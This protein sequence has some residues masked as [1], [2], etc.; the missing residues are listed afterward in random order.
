MEVITFL[1]TL[2]LRRI[3]LLP[4][5]L[6]AMVFAIVRWKRHPR[7]SLMTV[8]ALVIYLF[9]SLTFAIILHWLPSLLRALTQTYQGLITVQNVLLV[10]EDF[11]YAGVLILLVAAA[12][13]QRPRQ[14]AT[15]N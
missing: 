10:C 5:L 12:F 15:T 2:L 1:L 4:L 9:D 14:L 8:L 11:V 6:G 7:V 3:L 13:S